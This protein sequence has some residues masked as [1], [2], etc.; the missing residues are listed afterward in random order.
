MF[1]FDKEELEG[2]APS[3]AQKLYLQKFGYVLPPLPAGYTHNPAQQQ[4]NGTAKVDNK[5]KFNP[6]PS[7]S[8][9]AR[10]TM[11]NGFGNALGS[12]TE[13]VNTL[14][15]RK[16]GKNKKRIQ[17]SF[18][19]NMG[20]SASSGS[21]LAPSANVSSSIVQSEAG[22]SQIKLQPPPLQTYSHFGDGVD[23]TSSAPFG[24]GFDSA[25]D[26]DWGGD[27]Q[28][29]FEGGMD[30]DVPINSLDSS[31]SRRGNSEEFRVPK[32]RTLGG[33]RARI[34]EHE[35]REIK[36]VPRAEVQANPIAGTSSSLT[37]PPPSLKTYISTKAEE[38]GDILE[39]KNTEDGEGS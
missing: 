4:P 35:V 16:G 11:T 32:A 34:D 26:L 10:Q 38:T 6:S 29:A 23:N 37:F 18:V 7:P 36:A 39:A 30:M 20:D 1:N 31:K 33:D 17:P 19:S 25:M 28:R 13:H 14:V 9:P 27:F 24:R 8:A 15:A 21:H 3:D 5:G 12:S 22:T 2:I